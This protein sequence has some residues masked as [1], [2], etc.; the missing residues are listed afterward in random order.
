[1][2]DKIRSIFEKNPAA[3]ARAHENQKAVR[4]RR[5]EFDPTA[6]IDGLGIIE[7]GGEL[8]VAFV[9]HPEDWEGISVSPENARYL[10]QALLHMA[11][12]CDLRAQGWSPPEDENPVEQAR[13]EEPEIVYA[14]E[15]GLEQTGAVLACDYCGLTQEAV[16][17]TG[18]QCPEHL[19]H[20]FVEQEIKC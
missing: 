10:A 12:I 11:S 20:H 4:F 14:S 2:S 3:G 7:R 16:E 8:V 15:R 6:N 19:C 5:I 9:S 18:S 1:M 13:E 17:I